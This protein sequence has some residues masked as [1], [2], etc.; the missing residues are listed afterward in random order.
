MHTKR[1]GLSVI[2]RLVSVVLPVFGASGTLWIQP[3]AP[4]TCFCSPCCV[5]DGG[6]VTDLTQHKVQHN[7]G[8]DSLWNLHVTFSEKRSQ[9]YRPALPVELH[10][11]E[12]AHTPRRSGE[13]DL[14][15]PIFLCHVWTNCCVRRIQIIQS[16]L[17]Q[18]EG[19]TPQPGSEVARGPSWAGI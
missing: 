6:N 17:M 14:R 15:T 10:G 3:A 1:A 7:I 18:H 5:S 8:F 2:H 16:E 11:S 13:F 12:L 9:L 19:K 4:L